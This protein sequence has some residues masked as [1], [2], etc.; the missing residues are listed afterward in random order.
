[1]AILGLPALRPLTENTPKPMLMVE[2]KPRWKRPRISC[3]RL[4]PVLRFG[5][6]ISPIR[7][8]NIRRWCPLGLRDPLSGRKKKAL[9][10]AGAL[11]LL[12]ER[13]PQS[14]LIV[15]NGDVLTKVNF[16]H[17]LDFHREHAAA[18]MCVREY[19]F[20]VPYGV[21]NLTARAS[22]AWSRSRFIP[23]S[24]TPVFTSSIP[25]AR[26]RPRRPPVSHDLPVR[27]GPWPRDAKPPPFPSANI[28]RYRPG[29][30]SCPRQ[31]AITGW[32][33][34]NKFPHRPK[35]APNI[36]MDIH[37]PP[38]IARS[39]AVPSRGRPPLSHPLRLCRPTRFCRSC[40]ISN[41]R[42]NSIPGKAAHRRQH[43]IDHPPRRRRHRTLAARRRR[44]A[45]STG[46]GAGQTGVELCNL[47]P[48]PHGDGR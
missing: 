47:L 28:D 36:P 21:T 5:S 46:R 35:K 18:T 6:T 37:A 27:S 29:R 39:R 12:P 9:G 14:P 32:A 45:G 10:T 13:C 7:G 1:M 43:E 34:L 19:D 11:S 15:M 20:R 30:R 44:S 22:T 26:R 33:V 23:F 16:S 25:S 31:M 17:L 24:S 2:V 38:R 40:V 41:Q 8:R 4:S 48:P 3:S 42:P